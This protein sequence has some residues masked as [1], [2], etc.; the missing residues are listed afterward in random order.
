MYA[1]YLCQLNNQQVTN[2]EAPKYTHKMKYLISFCKDWH[3]HSGSQTEQGSGRFSYNLPLEASSQL[4]I[5]LQLCLGKET[6]ENLP[7]NSVSFVNNSTP[8]KGIQ[9]V[10]SQ[11]LVAGMLINIKHH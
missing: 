11:Y 5:I 7:N 6:L 1:A 8:A 10:F 3:T 9:L 4:F 2:D